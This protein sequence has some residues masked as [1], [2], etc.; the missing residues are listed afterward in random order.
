M[1]RSKGNTGVDEDGGTRRTKTTYK[2]QILILR[3]ASPDN[4]A[5]GRHH[6]DLDDVVHARPP[7]ARRGSYA[8][9]GGVAAD[10][11]PGTR[12]VRHGAAT[13]FVE[14]LRQV[15]QV[16]APADSSMP[17]RVIHVQV[18]QVYQVNCEGAV[19]TAE[20]VV[21]CFRARNRERESA[22][23]QL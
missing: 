23:V 19:L 22:Q 9:H 10:S 5:I 18:L 11:H 20:A 3:V 14:P 21:S 7:H 15:A 8:A 2:K 16:H 13:R 12:P 1:S 17:G 6:L 4:T